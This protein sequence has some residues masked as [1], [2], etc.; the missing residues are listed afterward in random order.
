MWQMHTHISDHIQTMLAMP[1][2]FYIG[3]LCSA[4]ENDCA[5]LLV[6]AWNH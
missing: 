4:G 6:D 5:I 3:I 1:D 2:L